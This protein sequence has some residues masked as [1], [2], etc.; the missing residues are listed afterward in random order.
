MA[1]PDPPLNVRRPDELDPEE[2][3]EY[4]APPLEDEDRPEVG[5]SP[6]KVDPAGGISTR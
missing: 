3:A 1:N 4:V 6:S 5:T 2:L